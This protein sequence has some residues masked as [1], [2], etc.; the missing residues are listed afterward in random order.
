MTIDTAGVAGLFFELNGKHCGNIL[1]QFV[2]AR[3]MPKL[4]LYQKPLDC[5][6]SFIKL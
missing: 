2:K 6:V 4:V 1:S 5:S 3:A